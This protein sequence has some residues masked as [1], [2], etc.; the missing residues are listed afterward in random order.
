MRKP[1]ASAFG[2]DIWGLGT[3]LYA[4]TEAG[5]Y[6]Y[7]HHGQNDPAINASVRINPETGDAL[8]AFVSG[9]QSLATAL[10]YE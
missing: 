1:H 3:I 8:I 4:P 10:G 2:A 9:G 6:I 5:D 7:G